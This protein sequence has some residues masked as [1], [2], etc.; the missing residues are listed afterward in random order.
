MH[1]SCAVVVSQV[2]FREKHRSNNLFLA[3]RFLTVPVQGSNFVI[4]RSLAL[5]LSSR[6]E[7]EKNFLLNV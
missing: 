7:I 1:Y 5:I 3:E 6:M 2:F 4:S